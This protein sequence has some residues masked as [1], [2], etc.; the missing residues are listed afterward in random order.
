MRRAFL[1]VVLL[2]SIALLII[3]IAWH[4][5]RPEPSGPTT[6]LDVVLIGVD[7]MDWFLLRDLMGEGAMHSTASLLSRGVT[8][9]VAADLP[10]LPEIGWTVIGRGRGLSEDELA[11]VEEPGGRLYGLTP[12]LARLV[13]SAGGRALTVGWPASWP[14][15]GEHGMVVAPYLPQSPV[16]ERGLTAAI[17]GGDMHA[18]PQELRERVNT[19]VARSEEMLDPEFRR[20]I[21]DGDAEGQWAAHVEAARWAFLADLTTIDIA[22]SLM[23]DESPDLTMICLGGLDAVSHRFL[24]PAMPSFFPGEGEE[25][26]AYADVLDNYYQFVDTC[27]ERIRRLTDENTVIIICSAYGM[28][29]TADIPGVSG[30]HGDGPPGVFIL[31]GPKVQQRNKPIELSTQD[32][33]P[34]VLALLGVT[35]PTDMDGRVLPDA[36]P[37]RLLLDFPLSYGG[38]M[39][40]ADLVPEPEAVAGAD[41][42]VSDRLSL[43]RRPR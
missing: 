3:V 11:T 29:P 35:I 9:E 2:V 23:A 36:M 7:G 16:H 14:A 27:I 38:S 22:A 25:S 34:T 18:C 6:G 31:R 39:R 43:L 20:L 13:D 4:P 1:A 5:S 28:H 15:D 8:G 19:L 40:I 30:T 32:V 41:A 12:Q 10:A 37:E 33:S 21:F 26:A 17:L 42:L 24:A